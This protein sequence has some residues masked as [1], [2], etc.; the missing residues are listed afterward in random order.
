[1]KGLIL[2][3]GRG[4]RLGYLTK[5]LNKH[6]L[7]IYDKPMIFYPIATLVSAGIKD[8]AIVCNKSDISTFEKLLMN[9]DALNISFSLIEQKNEKGIPSAIS[10]ASDFLDS[11][12]TLVI[13]GDNLIYGPFLG[14]ELKSLENSKGATCF[15]KNVSNPEKY[16][17][18]EIDLNDEIRLV[19]K[20]TTSNSNL[21]IIGLYYF[22][23]SLLDKLQKIEI[24]ERGETEILEVLQLFLEEKNLNFKKLH[25]SSVWFDTGDVDDLL[26]A[27]NFVKSS[28]KYS[29]E[30]ILDPFE[31]L[32]AKNFN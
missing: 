1:M 27:A 17:V 24:S 30:K 26:D 8:I 3:G 25:R 15:T 29:I 16:G 31:I 6:L 5:V 2:A 13:L 32:S 19:E 23:E 10:S 7:P 4:S 18:C 22:D 9:F 11:S 21:A 12:G 20:P 28:Q 14:K